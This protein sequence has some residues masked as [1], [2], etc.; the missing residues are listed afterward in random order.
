VDI[1]IRLNWRRAPH[2]AASALV[3]GEFAGTFFTAVF[4]VARPS[5]RA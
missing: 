3:R 4:P 2:R 5:A 1:P